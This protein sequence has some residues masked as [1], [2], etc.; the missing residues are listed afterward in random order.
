MREIK[1]RGWSAA[2]GKWIYGCL[3]DNL[4]TNNKDKSK[5]SYII[6][7]DIDYYDCWEDIASNIDDFEVDTKT[8]GQYIG[9]KDKNG[10]E[11]YEGDVLD[12]Q[13]GGFI[14]EWEYSRNQHHIQL[15]CDVAFDAEVT[16]NI[17]TELLKNKTT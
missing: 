4:F 8:V 12:V 5:V 16:S 1:F 10:K 3:V 6:H 14:A 7:P 2:L 11:I 15:G 13:I 9:L 17:Y